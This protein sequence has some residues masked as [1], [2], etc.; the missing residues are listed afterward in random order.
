MITR[1]FAAALLAST[2]CTAAFADESPATDPDWPCA[3]QLVPKISAAQVWTGP[4]ADENSAMT[5]P[6]ELSDLGRSAMDQKITDD[7]AVKL[8]KDYFAKA[9]D[10]K[11]LKADIPTIFIVALTE[12]NAQRERQI[13]GIKNFTRGQF[14]LSKKLADDVNELDKLTAG[15][16]AKD[17]TPEKA[18]EDRLQ[19]ERRVFE[20]REHQVKYLCETPAGG[21]ARL[22]IVARTLEEAL[23][24]K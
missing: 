19:L 1:L 2:A 22:G 11:K 12:T 24:K 16:P 21:E 7:K 14:A 10:H 23:G 17:G 18:I 20:D 15:Q 13:S 3:Q 4:L 8:L 5:A 6:P 9:K